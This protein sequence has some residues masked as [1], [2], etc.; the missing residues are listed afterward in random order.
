MK[1]YAKKL[2]LNRETLRHLQTGEV[3]RVAGGSV[4]CTSVACVE[5]SGCECDTQGCQAPTAALYTCS[6]GGT[7]HANCTITWQNC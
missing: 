6:A 4:N 3:M 1:K 7:S 5:Y 2:S